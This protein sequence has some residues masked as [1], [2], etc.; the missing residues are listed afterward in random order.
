MYEDNPINGPSTYVHRLDKPLMV[1][2]REHLPYILAIHPAFVASTCLTY[3]SVRYGAVLPNA[4]VD[5]DDYDAQ[6]GPADQIPHRLHL[7]G[8]A[9]DGCHVYCCPA[10]RKPHQVAYTPHRHIAECA[11]G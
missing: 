8:P 1:A 11:P 10:L 5:E 2:A 3:I 7:H 9:G 4:Y 6:Q